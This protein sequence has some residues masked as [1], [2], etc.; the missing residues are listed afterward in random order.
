MIIHSLVEKGPVVKYIGCD[1]NSAQHRN[2][3]A[4]T[5]I[6][7]TER[8]RAAPPRTASKEA[9]Q[10]QLILA[11]IRSV[12]KYGLPDTTMATV[13]GEAGLSQG[14][15]NL[16]FQSKENLLTET[17]RYVAD[18]YKTRFNKTLEE[19]GP[20]AAE[21]L[22]AL[23]ELDLRPTIMNR[24]KTPVWFAFW[25]ESKSRPTY[26]KICALRDRAYRQEIVQDLLRLAQED[27]QVEL[28]GLREQPLGQEADEGN[29]LLRRLHVG[30]DQ[31]VGLPGTGG[32]PG[33]GHRRP[34]QLD[35]GAELT[36]VTILASLLRDRGHVDH[37]C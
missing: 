15:I 13:A 3:M 24:Q 31:L 1:T 37:R 16:H 5:A 27:E 14:I 17:L 22:Q 19:A 28:V 9:R 35:V 32:H 18:E 4:T 12:A 34:Q 23:I 30:H 36:A 2:V 6:R 8:K 25:G 10:Q 7:K 33:E 29:D 20:G 26:R 21:K 11:T